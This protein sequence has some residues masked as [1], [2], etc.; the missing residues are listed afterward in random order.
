MKIENST[1][2]TL[3]EFQKF[4]YNVGRVHH[5]AMISKGFWEGVT[6]TQREVLILSELI[7][8]VEALRSN[9]VKKAN[10]K[11]FEERLEALNSSINYDYVPT[12]KQAGVAH[13][14][15][16]DCFTRYIKDSFEDELAGTFLRLVD[17]REG[18][19]KP[20]RLIE[21]IPPEDFMEFVKEMTLLTFK[22]QYSK[23]ISLLYAYCKAQE[24]DIAY[25]VTHAML[26]NKTRA[27]KH[28][29]NF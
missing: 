9:P 11:D 10:V 4:T 12:E 17:T 2:Q 8:G 19:R 23:A 24:I 21:A 29:K 7:E 15:Y 14:N 6:Q 27:A 5:R 18:F 26:Y 16:A 25:F 22:H 28:G 13:K 1:P 3:E 20:K